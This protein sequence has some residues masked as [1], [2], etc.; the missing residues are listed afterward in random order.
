MA[1][2]PPHD[3]LQ[4]DKTEHNEEGFVARW[5]S[6]IFVAVFMTI[7]LTLLMGYRYAVETVYNDWY[8]YQVA[9]HTTAVLSLVGDHAE[10]EH[11]REKLG[12]PKELR[13]R[14][15][16]WSRG[17]ESET[18]EDYLAASDAPLSAWEA[19][20]YRAMEMRQSNAPGERGPR[21]QFI[22]RRGLAIKVRELEEEVRELEQS[23]TATQEQKAQRR[24]ELDKMRESLTRMRTDKDTT[25]DDPTYMFY[26]IV[27][28][29]CGA[30]EVMAIFFAA[31]VA[32]PTRWSK[33]LVGLVVGIPAMY[34]VNIFRLSCL[35][36]IGA[37][38]TQH[39]YFNFAHEYVWQA[40]YIIFVVAAWMFWVEY[41]VRGRWRKERRPANSPA[42]VHEGENGDV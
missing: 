12:D 1:E 30:I 15:A 6:A 40:V 23:P 29:E 9:R 42:V 10:L 37:L 31:V 28:S 24:E 34:A 11:G 22:M 16:A 36:V 18:P 20:D 35:G 33:K 26:F 14:M 25:D 7:V 21:V 32:F 39:K 19:W 38:D 3:T 41:V 5:R 17:A 8:L 13:A 2:E 4:E 27:V